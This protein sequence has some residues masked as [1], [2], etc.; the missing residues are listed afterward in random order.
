ML[1]VGHKN[2]LSTVFL[3]EGR[4]SPGSRPVSPHTGATKEDEQGGIT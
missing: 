1:M 4:S 3:S 2:D